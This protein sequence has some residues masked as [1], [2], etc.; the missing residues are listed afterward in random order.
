MTDHLADLVAH[1][2]G[3]ASRVRCVLHIT[4][5]VAKS[6]LKPFDSPKKGSKKN[7]NI[8]FEAEEETADWGEDDEGEGDE[9]EDE[10]VDD[11]ENEADDL[12]GW[13]DEVESLS[14]DDRVELQ[15]HIRPLKSILVRVSAK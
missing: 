9:G 2:S 11:G 4:N 6:L 7:A 14:R 12:D 8:D 3:S 10:L 13:V 1:F 15:G 5:L